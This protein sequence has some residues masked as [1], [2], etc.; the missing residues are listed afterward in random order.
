MRQINNL[1][2]IVIKIGTNVLTDDK[3]LLNDKII[4]KLVE[5][6]AKIKKE[7]NKLKKKYKIVLVHSSVLFFNIKGLKSKLFLED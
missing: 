7:D 6:I 5:Q 2:K 1:K 4:K 3:G